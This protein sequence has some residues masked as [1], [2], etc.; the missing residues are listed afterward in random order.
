MIN[1]YNIN[2]LDTFICNNINKYVIL[3]YFGSKY[4]QPCQKLLTFLDNDDNKLLMPKLI[5]GYIDI[6]NHSDDI[7]D[8][9]NISI[10]PTQI[11]IN[12]TND[13][14]I[15]QFAKIEGY[16]IIKLQMEYNNYVNQYNI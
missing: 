8:I 11:L 3:L 13:D 4:C 2:E 12:L 16:D 5:V 10:L 9:Y 6:N 1:I 14:K 15:I 7:G